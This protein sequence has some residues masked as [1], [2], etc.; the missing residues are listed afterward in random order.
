[1]KLW[2]FMSETSDFFYESLSDVGEFV[3]VIF[4]FAFGTVCVLF[5]IALLVGFVLCVIDD[6]KDRIRLYRLMRESRRRQ[7]EDDAE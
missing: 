4:P 6:V 3:R 7:R 5:F 1:M 2:E